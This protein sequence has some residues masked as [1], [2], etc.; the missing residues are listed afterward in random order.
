MFNEIVKEIEWGGRKLTISTG[1][2]AR[3]A[4]ASVIVNY[5]DTT[6]MCN[7][8]AKKK[9]KEGID[10]FP[11]TVNYQEKTYAAGKIPGGFFKREGRLSQKET[12]TSRLIDRPIRP[13]FH[14]DY[15]NE[16]QII[17]TVLSFD[18]ENDAD[19]PALIGASAAL[20]ISD[21]P[22]LEPIAAAKIAYIDGSLVLNPTLTELNDTSLD[23]T[24]AGTADSVL[25]VESEADQ[26]SS[27]EM[28][29]AVSFGLESFKPVIAL[30]KELVEE[31]GK[32]KWVVESNNNP[33]FYKKLSTEYSDDFS[34]AFSITAK[35]ERVEA[36]KEVCAKIEEQHLEEDG[37]NANELSSYI[38]KL[39]KEVV[40]NK[41]FNDERIDG[42]K[43]DEVRNIASETNLL[44]KVHG[45]ALFTRGETQALSVITLGSEDDEQLIDGLEG[46]SK[47]RFMLH[48]N[49]PPYSVGEVGMLRAPGRREIGHGKLA[50]KSLSAV[51]PSVEEFPYAIRA[52]SEITESNGSS[53]MATVCATSMALMSSGVPISKPVSGIAMGLVKEGE[54]FKILSDIMGDEDHLGDM[55][56]K[57]AGTTDGITA[58]QMDIKITGITFEIFSKALEQADAGRAHIL[59]EMSK[60]I[61]VANSDLGENVP[62]MTSVK[63]KEEK[64]REVIGQ[65]GKVIKKICED[66]ECKIS[67]EDSGEVKIC[68]PDRKAADLALSIIADIVEEA[69]IGSTYTGIVHK[70]TDYGAFVNFLSNAS[71][72]IHI[73]E[74]SNKRIKSVS[75]FLNE[76]DEIKFKIVG[77]DRDKL[78][79]SYKAVNG[80]IDG[81]EDTEDQEEDNNVE[82]TRPERKPRSNNKHRKPRNQSRDNFK[83]PK[84]EKPKEDTKKK[85]KLFFW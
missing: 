10:F 17:C 76:G 28:L 70:I 23:L 16:T 48:Y 63:I 8:T 52:V 15:K 50:K 77:K 37:S 18:K 59:E 72:L 36:V 83:K 26:L 14:E 53:S 2:I 38:K 54:K 81:S 75:E 13:M 42:R 71:G 21:I 24:L 61:A 12:L 68:A 65:G 69:E 79:L 56:F 5:G 60:T 33:D 39:E 6:V 11:L 78:R 29:D 7:V 49:F 67:I 27:K 58:L 19:I 73:S 3:Q 62:I 55:D 30:I 32:E 31:V 74:F 66:S 9:P 34:K 47:E 85:K 84:E 4:N 82:S 51:I 64:I 22:F 40:R 1:K 35:L 46:N 45:S 57:V 25:M 43:L 41:V 44:A 20:S 80:N